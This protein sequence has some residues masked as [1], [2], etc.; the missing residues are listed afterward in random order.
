MKGEIYSVVLNV[1][2][3]NNISNFFAAR[4]F[5]TLRLPGREMDHPKADYLVF[6]LKFPKSNTRI[7]RTELLLVPKTMHTRSFARSC[8]KHRLPPF[9]SSVRLF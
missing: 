9:Q 5:G 2:K 6:R 1:A 8:T 4:F 3:K 7:E